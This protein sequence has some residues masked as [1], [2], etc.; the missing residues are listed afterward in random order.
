MM[1]P[2]AS[3]AKLRDGGEGPTLSYGVE[4]PGLTAGH[5]HLGSS[6]AEPSLGSPIGYALSSCFSHTPITPDARRHPV[7][8]RRR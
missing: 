5:R 7:A 6:S 4:G 8:P 3:A 2:C 1:Q